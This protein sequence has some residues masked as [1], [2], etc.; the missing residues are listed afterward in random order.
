[1]THFAKHQSFP[2]PLFLVI[3]DFGKLGFESVTHPEDTREGIVLDIA[4]GQI[5]R[6]VAVIESNPS[7]GWSRDITDDVRAEVEQRVAESE[8]A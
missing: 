3:R 7:E 1:M 6:V 4:S 2:G 8:A 5:D